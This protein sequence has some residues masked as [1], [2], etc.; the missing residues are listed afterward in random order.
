MSLHL[1]SN[2]QAERPPPSSSSPPPLHP[3]DTHTNLPHGPHSPTHTLRS[4]YLRQTETLSA[5]WS[6]SRSR[7]QAKHRDDGSRSG[8]LRGEHGYYLL[9]RKGRLNRIHVASID[10]TLCPDARSL[11]GFSVSASLLSVDAARIDHS[12]PCCCRRREKKQPRST[13]AAHVI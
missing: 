4:K 2:Q 12:S 6:G 7:R 1:C 13:R 3:H 8:D 11:K 9:R 5:I 10:S